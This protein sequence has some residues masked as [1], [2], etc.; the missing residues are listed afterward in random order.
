MQTNWISYAHRMGSIKASF[1]RELLKVT[2]QP[3]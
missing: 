2:Q 1:I 3:T